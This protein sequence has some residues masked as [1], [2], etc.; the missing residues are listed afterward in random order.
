MLSYVVA[1][2]GSIA[3]G[4]LHQYCDYQSERGEGEMIFPRRVSTLPD[5]EMWFSEP[6]VD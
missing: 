3:L 5:G 4:I 6:L 1:P 2:L